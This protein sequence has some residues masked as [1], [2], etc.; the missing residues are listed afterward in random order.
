METIS[1]ASAIPL[2]RRAHNGR[3]GPALDL[4]DN[5]ALWR[6]I[7]VPDI[8]MSRSG[9]SD[10]G[11]LSIDYLDHILIGHRAIRPIKRLTHQG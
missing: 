11:R 3:P 5:R 9:D 6:L 10:R 4:G 7:T 2:I 1:E 8:C